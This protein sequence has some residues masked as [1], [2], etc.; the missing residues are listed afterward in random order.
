[1]STAA[2]RARNSFAAVGAIL[3]NPDLRRLQLAFFAGEMAGWAYWIVVVLYAYAHGGGVMVGVVGALRLFGSAIVGPFAG[4]VADRYPR[5]L[6]L[7]GTDSIRTVCLVLAA[8]VDAS[9]GPSWLVISFV[10]LFALVQSAFRPAFAALLPTLARTPE[11]LT[12]SN[13]TASAVEA[14][15]LFLGPTVA[16]L[17]VAAGGTVS[18]FLMGAALFAWSALLFVLVGAREAPRPADEAPQGIVAAAVDGV[19]A[20]GTNGNLAVIVGMF[21]AQTLVCGAFGVLTVLL[22]KNTLGTGD[23]GVGYLN[24]AFGIGS[25]IGSLGSLGLVG[26][27]RLATTFGIGV[28]LWGLPLV[29]VGIKPTIGIAI[30]LLVVVGLGNT[31]VDVAG[32]T[33]LQRAVPD[34]VLARVTGALQSLM[35][36]A[37]G[38][39]AFAAPFVADWVG[40]RW[41]FVVSGLILPVLVAAFW[42]RIRALDTGVSAQLGERL[43]LIGM[44][45]ILAPLPYPLR[46]TMANRMEERD[47]PA[48]ET[49]FQAGD[50]GDLFWIIAE[51]EIAITPPGEE[52][53]V[54]RSGDSFGEIALLRDVPRTAGA[55]ARTSA[56]LYG[57]D[58]DT[59]VA[60]VTGH[61]DSE[62]AAEATI[63]T[64]LGVRRPDAGF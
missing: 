29:I 18:G 17:V 28:L 35:M 33:L 3:R 2:G 26:S 60:A 7:V 39:G 57:L 15:T 27:R 5:R 34:H 61:A 51:G 58:R 32:Y 36:A 22:S 21:G 37:T 20:I 14:V 38:A 62:A 4:V 48:A 6:V 42:S 11:D 64:R 54:L 1:V 30:A 50:S 49:L 59:F 23:A 43:R 9:D 19:K 47:L 46:E 12:A 13:V 53:R 16:G 55:E 41:T 52:P 10:V 40:V 56:R 25:I 24:S 63:A 44:Q 8:A 45:S 31:L